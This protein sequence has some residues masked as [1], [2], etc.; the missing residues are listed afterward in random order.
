[1]L[2]RVASLPPHARDAAVEGYLGIDDVPAPCSAPPGDHLVGYHASGVASVVRAL[3]EVPVD[4]DDIVIDLGSGLG[5]VLFLAHLLTGAGARGI[6]IQPALVKRARAAAA[7]LDIHVGFTLGDARHADLGDG[8]V[9]FLYAPF[10]GPV[11]ADVVHRLRAVAE[12]HAI[13][14]C[15]LGVDLDRSASWLVA[16]RLDSFWLTVYDSVLAAA[17]PR[18][19]RAQSPLGQAAEVIAFEQPKLG[20]SLAR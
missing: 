7:T 4:A 16:R 6:E 15:A 9:F 17:A 18:A 5:K 12:R 1:M 19:R 2:A 20:P 10:T 13:V 11:L 8:T 3:V 14:V